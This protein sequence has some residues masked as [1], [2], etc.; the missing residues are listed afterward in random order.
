MILI[1]Y[2]PVER[3]C[4]T[5]TRRFPPEWEL[6]KPSPYLELA[7]F[8]SSGSRIENGQTTSSASFL[9]YHPQVMLIWSDRA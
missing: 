8:L 2:P 5:L 4:S 1:P 7:V 9:V 6:E 3:R